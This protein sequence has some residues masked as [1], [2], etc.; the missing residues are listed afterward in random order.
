[1]SDEFSTLGIRQQLIGCLKEMGITEPTPIQAKAIPALMAGKDLVAQA[2]TGTGKTLAFL[3]PILETIEPNKPYVQALIITPTRELALQITKEATK[4]GDKLGISAL[5]LY[6]GHTLE[7]QINQLKANPHIVIGTPGR[8]LDH[9]RRKTLSLIGVSKLVLDEA[10]QMLHMGFLDDIEAII[11][12]TSSKR[13]T[14]LFSATIPPKIRSLATRYMQKPVDIRVQTQHV[15]L[16]EINQVIVEITQEEKLARLCTM[17]DEYRPYLAMVFC[18][19]KLRA[20]A[21]GTE[22]AQ[23]GYAVDE[24]HG[25]LSQTKREQVM[26]RFRDAKL[27][28]LVVTDIAARGLDIEGITHIFNYDIPHDVESYIHRIGRTGR[29][30]QTGTAITFVVP[31]EQT[32]LRTIEHGIRASIKKFK[33]KEAREA[34]ALAASA[35]EELPRGRAASSKRAKPAAAISKK[36][37]A[38]NAPS[39]SGINQ[40]SR[41]KPKADEATASAKHTG[42]RGKQSRRSRPS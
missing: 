20:I 24:L 8:L 23:R 42:A 3:L 15:T 4:L 18:H 13:Q 11:S 32:Y 22:L 35:E 14:M 1:M 9:F 37:P 26:K 38:K 5:T 31:G 19:T 16:D 41:R 30:G 17:I 29:A 25:D 33:S 36:L 6:G 28:I 40:R 39:H 10:D 2:Q 27:Q 7:K 34:K 12:Q 21:L